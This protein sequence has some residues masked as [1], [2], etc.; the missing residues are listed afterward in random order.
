MCQSPVQRTCD[1]CSD[2]W[3]HVSWPQE[4]KPSVPLLFYLSTPPPLPRL[5][6][7]IYMIA[8]LFI[9][10]LIL[11]ITEHTC[12][13]FPV[14]KNLNEDKKNITLKQSVNCLYS[15]FSTAYTHFQHFAFKKKYSQI[16]ELHTQN[17]KCLTYL[18]KWSIAFKISQSIKYTQQNIPKANICKPLCHNINSR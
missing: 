3:S 4:T 10:M 11:L 14:P 9:G 16:Q 6:D 1:L 17:V 18:A 5:Q 15:F 13:F 2:Q 8:F 12:T 7:S